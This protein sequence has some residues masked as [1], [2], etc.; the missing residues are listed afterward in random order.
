MAAGEA[1]ADV[2]VTAT[3]GL[4]LAAAVLAEISAGVRA[5]DVSL[6]RPVLGEVFL[7]RAGPGR[8]GAGRDGGGM[9]AVTDAPRQLTRLRH[10]PFAIV[11]TAGAPVVTVIIFGYIFGSAISVAGGG[12]YREFL[13][14]G[15][16]ATA[17][18]NIPPS[19][20]AMPQP[21]E[22]T[23]LARRVTISTARAIRRCPG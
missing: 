17:A 12:S 16:Y 10:D 11:L 18:A 2:T 1:G 6:R 23:D 7:D 3:A 9:S 14:P 8:A 19:M 13:L 4:D 20:V 5:A 22:I 21:A 15:P